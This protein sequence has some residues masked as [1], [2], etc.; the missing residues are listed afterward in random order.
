MDSALALEGAIV[1]GRHGLRGYDAIHLAAALG[2]SK[3]EPLGFASY[4]KELLA[5]AGAE[6]L[7][8]ISFGLALTTRAS[9]G[10]IRRP[11]TWRRYAK[12]CWPGRRNS[13]RGRGVLRIAPHSRPPRRLHRSGL[14]L[15]GFPVPRRAITT[16]RR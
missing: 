8:T 13:R 3:G 4:D 2:F 9:C 7:T 10:R 11:M 16:N 6:G 15:L 12:S 1:G 14:L 5:A